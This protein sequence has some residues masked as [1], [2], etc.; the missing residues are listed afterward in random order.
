MIAPVL[1]KGSF[2]CIGCA[3]EVLLPLSLEEGQTLARHNLRVLILQMPDRDYAL[4]V[5]GRVEF[6]GN[7][8][9]NRP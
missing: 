3:L 8:D 7:R 5:L 9:L 2:E 6:A 1:I 4:L